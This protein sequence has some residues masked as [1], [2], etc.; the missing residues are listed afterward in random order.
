MYVYTGSAWTSFAATTIL[1][2][3][4][5]TAAG[6]ETSESGPDDNGNTL[7]YTAGKEQVYLNGVLLVRSQDYTATNG[8]SITAL[9]PALA[10]SDVL[11]IF[12]I[13]SFAVATAIPVT[14]FDAKGDLLVAS[15][16]DEVGR[17]PVGTND[18][19]LTADS[20]QTLGVKWATVTANLDLTL[21]AQTAAYTLVLADKNKLVTVSSTSNLTV[22]IPLNSSVAYSTGAQIHI[23][24]LNTGTVTVSGTAGVTVNSTGAT[25]ASPTLR[26]QY[27]TATCIKTDTNTWLV[28]GDIA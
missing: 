16:A 19:V 10:A 17:L 24:R 11:E 21:N 7:A 28:I 26:A 22:T 5:Y 4:R 12:A 23:A 15:N 6:G 8:T 27:S 18:Y 13:Q 2:R 14:T 25:T 3:Y 9:S 20:A 1:N